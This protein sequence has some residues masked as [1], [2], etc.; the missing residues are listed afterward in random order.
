MSA[1]PLRAN[2]LMRPASRLSGGWLDWPSTRA[3]MAALE[4][5]APG[6]N[7]YVGGCVR[8]TICGRPV[9][10]VDIATVM[11]PPAVLAALAAARVRAIPT[12]IEHGTVTAI[13]DSKSVEIT[14][15]R[16]DVATDG[17]RAIVA[18]TEDWAE[19]AARRDFRLNA[20]YAEP[21]GNIIEIVPGSV[22][23]AAAG[24]VIF[25][26]EPDAR[27]KEDYLRILRFY[28]FNAWYAAGIDAAGQAA[29]A[30]QKAGLARI[31]A[32][33]VWKELK[34]MLAAPDPAPALLAMEE[35]GVLEAVLPGAS[36]GLVQGLVAAEAEARLPP[37]PLR[38]LMALLPRRRRECGVVAAALRLSNDE[39]ARLSAW[40]DPAL[41]QVA[42]S[43]DWPALFYRHGTAAVI[44]RALIDAASGAAIDIMALAGMAAA[45]KAPVLPLG[46][47]DALAAGLAGRDVGAALARAEAAWVA[48]GFTLERAALL[49]LLTD[50][51]A[52]RNE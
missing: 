50:G 19:D 3:V 10:D 33:R 29:C 7:R 51:A 35:A 24:R 30:R 47:H 37:D 46:G 45:W 42:A 17:R 16:R 11:R 38:R 12:G 22:D 18:F 43:S 8:D 21:D 14:T 4:A 31:A 1:R 6:G 28:R 40:S 9:D 49:A 15:L 52:S 34:R 23:D 13:H 25:I 39:A 44:D 5:A 26:G 41:T 36:A 20:V 32:E 27:L 2:R 48:S